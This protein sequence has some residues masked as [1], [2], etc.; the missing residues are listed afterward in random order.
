MDVMSLNA[1]SYAS[2]L[3]LSDR[4]WTCPVC[5]AAHD[6]DLLAASNIKRFGL[7]RQNLIGTPAVSGAGDVESSGLPGAENRQYLG[8]LTCK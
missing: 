6:R 4:V 2:D 8:V 1:M 5:G 3:K 7:D